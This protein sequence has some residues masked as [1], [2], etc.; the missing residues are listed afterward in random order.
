MK[1]VFQFIKEKFEKSSNKHIQV[2]LI[3]GQKLKH[4][5]S[6][7]FSQQNTLYLSQNGYLDMGINTG[8]AWWAI[9]RFTFIEKGHLLTC[10]FL[11]VEYF[12]ACPPNFY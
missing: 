8:W 11:P 6:I 4:L 12:W 9:F 1:L 5:V 10:F 7:I 2:L 3:W